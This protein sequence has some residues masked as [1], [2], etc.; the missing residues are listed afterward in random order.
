MSM[1]PHT[2][3]NLIR[4]GLAM[5]IVAIAIVL[6]AYFVENKKETK[7]KTDKAPESVLVQTRT[8]PPGDHIVQITAMGQ[9]VPSLATDLKPRVSG[10]IIRVAPEFVPGGYFEKGETILEI[11]PADYALE[12]EKKKAIL[13]QAQAAL[14]LEMGRQAIAKDELK[15]L[16]KS[17]GAKLGQ[18]GLALRKP[19]LEQ[20]RADVEQARADLAL[21]ELDIARTRITAPFNALVSVRNANLGD[22]VS[23]QDTL[24]TL[25]STD[26]YW[27]E[28]SVPVHDMIYLSLPGADGRGGS[29]A[30]IMLDGNRGQRGGTLARMTGTLDTQS[31]LVSMLV[32]VP[33]PLLLDYA[34]SAYMLLLK[35]RQGADIFTQKTEKPP[36]VLGDYVQ[37]ALDGKILKNAVR[38]PVSA[39]RDGATV[40]TARAGQLAIRAVKIAYRDRN[41]AYITEGIE[42]G[43]ALVVSD[44]AA[45]VEG[46]PL[47]I[48][49]FRETTP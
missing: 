34:R 45:P 21:A 35:N 28:L 44:I 18:T 49:G 22:I 47:R 43:E 20:A 36:L 6:A 16:Q 24:A 2:S 46:M 5:L 15:I 42:P 10:E 14:D 17:T 1:L 11:D 23:A 33:D 48:E 32:S 9:V 27:I 8:F 30:T 39:L 13:R 41:Y 31:R 29:R 4:A 38:L 26:E 25:V 37:V 40:W 7:K 19:Q 3:S 12:I